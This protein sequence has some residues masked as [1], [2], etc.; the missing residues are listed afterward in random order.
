VTIERREGILDA[1]TEKGIV[2]SGARLSYSKWFEGEQPTEDLLG[3]KVQV[4]VDAGTKC[5]FLKRVVHVGEKAEGWK[6]PEPEKK[7]FFGGGGGRKF[8][9]E[10]LALK[11]EEGKRIA[12]SVAIDRAI[13]LFKEGIKIDEI[14]SLATA[15]EEYLLTGSLPRGGGPAKDAPET[16][17]PLSP[18]PSVP[19]TP[20]ESTRPPA[21]PKGAQPRPAKPKRLASQAVNAL[22]N[23]ALRGGVVDDWADFLQIVEEVL[24]V[25]GGSPYQ[26]DLPSFEKIESVIRTKLGQSSAA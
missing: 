9:P 5:T 25:K 24:K 1:V 13:S 7:G 18:A 10:E 26:M 22:F 21:P 12:R 4:V 16:P 2:L 8:S 19:S 14:A 20:P 15:V 17:A 6:P 3:S 23:Q 11:V